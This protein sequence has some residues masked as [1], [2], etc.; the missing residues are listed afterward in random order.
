MIVRD[1]APA[2]G[3]DLIMA[4]ESCPQ[5]SDLVVTLTNNPD[6]FARSRSYEQPRVFLAEE[7]GQ[8]AGSAAYAI[9]TV[10]ICSSPSSSQ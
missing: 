7:D 2:D 6:F 5:G 8:I 1:A 3:A 10:Q 4:M 9:R